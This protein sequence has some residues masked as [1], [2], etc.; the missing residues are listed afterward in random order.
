MFCT[1][2]APFLLLLA[3]STIHGETDVINKDI[4]LKN[5]DRTIDISTQLVKISNK[6]T[7]ENAGKSQVK[8]FI[9]TLEPEI[10]KHVAFL[11]ASLGSSSNDDSK[12][13]GV[14][15]TTLTDKNVFFRDIPAWRINLRQPLDAG[16]TVQIEVETSFSEELKPYPSHITQAENQFVNYEGN[17][18]FYSPYLCI[19]Q[20]T[21]VVLASATIESY[22]KVK[23]VTQNDKTITYGPYEN[24]APFSKG[25]LNVHSENNSP[26][27]TVT[28]LERVIEVSHWGNIAIEESIDLL[29][30]GAVLK[31]PFSRYE[32]QR[33]Q[34]GLSS[35]KSFKTVLPASAMDVY[36]RDEIGNISTSHLRNLDDA[37]EVDLRPRFPLFG[38]WK[39]HYILGYNLPSYEYMYNSGDEFVIK[40]RFIDHVYDDMHV[41][42]AT[43]K[44]I[45]P[46]G[47]KNIKLTT[48]YNVRKSPNAL[49]FTY[50]DTLGRPVII[51]H[52]DNLVENHIQDFELHYTFQKIFMLQE[53]FLVVIA[54]Y[55]LFVIVIVYVRLDFSISKDPASESKMKVSSFCDQIQSHHDNRVNIYQQYENAIQGFKTSKDTNTFQSTQKKLTTEVKNESKAIATIIAKMKVE[56]PDAVDKMNELQKLDQQMNEQIK[57]QIAYAER[58]VA[59]KM[60]KDLYVE[61]DHNV[62]KKKEEIHDKMESIISSL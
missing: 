41:E 21:N 7:I 51:A 25:L 9:F 10:K 62:S 8:S 46:E 31:G 2:F 14:V 22:T 47:A 35:I 34:N 15:V 55:L 5:V 23:P 19:K 38:G 48:P 56:A 28:N 44:V 61:A 26:F 59:G 6:I 1:N 36:Y 17:L 45:L 53:P 40:M 37:V 18:H 3:I 43:V 52:K 20:T 29:H 12:H 42:K 60:K 49:H 57:Q 50:L 11:G 33:D 13:L 30:S 24:V 27:M 32:Y 16:K 39:T 54:F 4:L 58:L